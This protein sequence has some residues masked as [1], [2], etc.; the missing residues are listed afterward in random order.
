MWRAAEII[1]LEFWKERDDQ[2]EEVLIVVGIVSPLP[3]PARLA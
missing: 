3:P 2:D 1:A